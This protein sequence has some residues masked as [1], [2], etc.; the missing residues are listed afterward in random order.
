[1]GWSPVRK[2]SKLI[3]KKFGNW[4]QKNHGAAPFPENQKTNRCGGNKSGRL[5]MTDH[6][7]YTII[8]HVTKCTFTQVVKLL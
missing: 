3:S 4:Y 7:L 1:L 6:H 5:S 2:S 8:L